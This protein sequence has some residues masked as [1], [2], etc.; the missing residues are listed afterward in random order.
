VKLSARVS[1]VLGSLLALCVAGAFGMHLVLSTLGG[2]NHQGLAANDRLGAIRQAEVDLTSARNQINIWLQRANPANVRAADGLLDAMASGTAALRAK[3]AGDA[4]LLDGLARLDAVRAAYVSSWGEMQR[5]VADRA[6]AA[7]R[8]DESGTALG[9]AVAALPVESRLAVERPIY[10][11]RIAVLRLRADPTPGNAAAADAALGPLDAALR[12]AGLDQDSE[13]AR[14]LGAWREVYAR[15]SAAA[16]RA[17]EVLVTFRDQGNQMSSVLTSLRER[18]VARA[19]QAATEVRDWL[20][21]AERDLLIF[22]GIILLAGLGLALLLLRSVVRPLLGVTAAIEAVA[23]GRLD[24]EIPHASRRDEIG[25]TAR[26]LTVFRDALLD[27]ER[28][29]AAAAERRAAAEAERAAALVAMAERVEHEAGAAVDAIAAQ[30]SAMADDAEAMAASADVVAVDSTMVSDATQTAQRNVQTV[31]AATEQLSASIR[32][33]TRQV[34]GAA[35]ATRRASEQGTLGRERIATLVRNV[36][37]IDGVARSIA[38]IAGQ[39]NLLALN[40]T[41]EAAR[42]GEAGKGFA[43]VAGEVKAL[44][45]QT[46]RATEEIAREVAEVA[47][48]TESAVAVVRSMADSVAEVDHAATAIAAAMEQQTAATQEISRAVSET[49]AATQEAADRVTTVAA[50]SQEVG[51]RADHVRKGSVTARDAVARLRRTM[52]RI[53]REASP[54]VERRAA[55]RHDLDA[56]AVLEGPGLPGAGVAVRLSNLSEGGCAVAAEKLALARGATVTLRGRGPLGALV[57]RAEVI[58]LP[59]QEPLMRLRFIGLGEA[60]LGALRD[61]LRRIDGA[62]VTAA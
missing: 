47:A 59:P 14:H 42:A 53:V 6:A 57:L 2:V 56:E 41:I 35:E 4:A 49:S 58:A 29:R 1:L 38:D 50:E 24:A 28:M 52:V 36:E 60:E 16:S 44:A 11:A 25:A 61:V 17:A 10:T 15:F 7:Q 23:A 5:A 34:V 39:T 62:A 43:V 22:S 20:D 18:E 48:A 26:A 30:T 12:G 13:V 3:A 32:E 40:A 31:A 51:K 55:R 21:Q 8:M 19:A 37:R 27:G 9:A 46:A 33:I 45:A 54:E